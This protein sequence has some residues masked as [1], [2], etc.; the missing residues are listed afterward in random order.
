MALLVAAKNSVGYSE[1]D[2]SVSNLVQLIEKLT[3]RIEALEQ[4]VQILEAKVQALEAE[5]G[6]SDEWYR[7]LRV[8]D[9]DTILISSGE[10]LRY[11]GINTPETVDPSGRKRLNLTKS[12]LRNRRCGLN[13]MFK[14]GT[15]TGDYWHTS[16]LKM[17]RL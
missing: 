17:A 16:I 14:S 6:T 5:K 2:Q 4:L 11:I 1:P 9:G 15:N 8:V 7:V 3:K 13:S 10:T 12:S